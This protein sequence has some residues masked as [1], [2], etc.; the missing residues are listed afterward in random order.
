MTPMPTTINARTAANSRD[1]LQSGAEGF[2]GDGLS[3]GEDL[4]VFNEFRLALLVS[5]AFCGGRVVE[6]LGTSEIA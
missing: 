4:A 5:S 2:A 3:G 6:L 1:F